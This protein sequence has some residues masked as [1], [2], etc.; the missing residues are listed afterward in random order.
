MCSGEEVTTETEENT[1]ENREVVT[2]QPMTSEGRKKKAMN[3]RMA[4]GCGE[5]TVMNQN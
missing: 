4:C 1:R 5:K 2:Y 3:Q